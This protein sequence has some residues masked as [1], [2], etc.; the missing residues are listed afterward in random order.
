MNVKQILERT[1][2][3]AGRAFDIIIQC[4]IVLSLISFSIETWPDLSNDTRRILSLI[5][6]GTVAIFSIEY[7]ARIAVADNRPRFI[8]SFYGL[9]DL[10]AILPFYIASGVDLRALRVFRLLR[11]LRILKLVRYSKALNRFHVAFLLAKEELILYG[12]VTIALIY[13]SGVGIYYFE[14]EAQPE[15]FASIFHSLWWAVAT[16]TTV[17]YGDVYPVTAGG[18]FFTFIILMIGLG[19]IA[20][21]AGL[22]ASALSRAREL[23]E[24]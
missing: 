5:E 18:K 12:C 9:V 4:L 17:G 21:P 22:V 6:T 24:D 1:D 13:L 7:L 2:T 23:E 8:F 11:I 20:I 16:L 10:F 3:R 15:L 19:V 14:T